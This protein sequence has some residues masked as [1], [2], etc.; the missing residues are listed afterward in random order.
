MHRVSLQKTLYKTTCFNRQLLT[1]NTI[2]KKTP[3]TNLIRALHGNLKPVSTVITPRASPLL[4][5][6]ALHHFDK[7][8]AARIGTPDAPATPHEI[9]IAE[10]THSSKY[11]LIRICQ[12]I[13]QALDTYIIEPFLT[14]RR[15][16]HILLLFLPVVA[17]VP[18]VFFGQ[19]V[20]Q[21]DK[22]GTLWWYDFLATQ[23]ERAGPTFIKV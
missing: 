18:V 2:F 5:A 8:K 14:V 12:H 9:E 21:Q 15:L 20:D 10:D 23:M 13:I 17:T 19:K 22:T 11:L 1:A 4:S 6:I 16:A 7:K 3:C